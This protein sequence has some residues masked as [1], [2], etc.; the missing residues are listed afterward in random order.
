MEE[1]TRYRFWILFF[2][3]VALT[4]CVKRTILIESNPPGA[5]VWVNEHPLP[6]VTPVRYEFITHGR[7]QFRLQ[8]S[9]FR[10][11]VAREM[12]KAPIYQWIPLDLVFEHM[13]PVKLE[14]RHAFRYD[15]SP[16]PP[17][18]QVVEQTPQVREAHLEDLS[19]PDPL[20]RRAAAIWLA[21]ERDPAHAK[22]A[23]EATFDTDPR[24]RA[25]A[26]EALRVIHGPKA[27][28][29]LSDLLQ[30]D[31][32]AEVRWAAATQLEALHSE[33]ALP[34]LRKALEQKEP[35]VRAGAAEALKGIPD[36]G[37]VDPLIRALKDKDTATRRAAAEG[38]GRIGDRAAVPPLMR[39]LFHHDFQ[40]RRRAAKSLRQLKDPAAG[41]ALAR[42]LHDW[43]P[44]LRDTA[45]EALVEFGDERVPPVLIR[46][47]RS[48][49]P[50]VRQHAAEVLGRIK[51]PRAVE[52]LA[53]AFRREPNDRTSRS[54][55]AALKSLGVE[56]D[57]G[58]E[59]MD[60]YRAHRAEE[61]REKRKELD[62]EKKVQ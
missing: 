48:W 40:T 49:K 39:A 23:L 10:E 14:D 50:A 12:V 31:P 42:S 26:L 41:L 45:A 57:A 17:A 55:L 43:D 34:A 37:S 36:P 3:S 5:R 19:D 6:E 1:I 25:V 29:R 54:M 44:V 56:M 24:V 7:Y 35:L 62:L 58:W 15:L 32:D 51:D 8:K 38:L 33:E 28:E 47:L 11:V 46:Y 60:Q 27:V 52:P 61:Q 30:S 22:A 59:E 18:E 16:L 9:G 21:R 20:K 2:L 4:G 53:R 13:V